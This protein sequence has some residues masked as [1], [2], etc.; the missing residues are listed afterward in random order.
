MAPDLTPRAA[1]DDALNAML[2]KPAT[3]LADAMLK[4]EHARDRLSKVTGLGWS[5]IALDLRRYG[6]SKLTEIRALECDLAATLQIG[7]AS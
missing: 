3:S 1:A 5:I 6:S 4:Y 7:A 2:I